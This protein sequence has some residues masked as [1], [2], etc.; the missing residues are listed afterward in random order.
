VLPYTNV[1]VN[2]LLFSRLMIL[3]NCDPVNRLGNKVKLSWKLSS[4]SKL[5]SGEYSLTYETPEGVVSLQCKTVVLT[6]PSYVAST[7]LRPLSVS[8]F[9]NSG[10]YDLFMLINNCFICGI[11]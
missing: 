1:L 7:L 8:F 4:I 11:F 10:L 5:D 6:I 9:L 3:A 2:F